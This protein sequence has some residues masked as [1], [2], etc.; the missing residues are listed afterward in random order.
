MINYRDGIEVR[1]I[2]HEG[3]RTVFL[4][5]TDEDILKDTLFMVDG[6][7]HIAREVIQHTRRVPRRLTIGI[8]R[9]E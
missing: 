8:D 1:D 4:I 3:N 2:V 7:V 6:R 9:I 5:T